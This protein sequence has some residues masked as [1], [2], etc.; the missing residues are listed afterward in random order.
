MRPGPEAIAPDEEDCA[1]GANRRG[2]MQG[3]GFCVDGSDVCLPDWMILYGMIDS[4][5]PICPGRAPW[6]ARIRPLFSA[7]LQHGKGEYL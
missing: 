6:A 4:R 5:S 2:Q 1:G 7:I 3:K